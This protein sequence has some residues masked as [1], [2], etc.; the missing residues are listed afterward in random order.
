MSRF[1]NPQAVL[2]AL[3]NVALSSK[4]DTGKVMEA[5]SKD[6]FLCRVFSEK[7]PAF[8]LKGGQSMLARTTFARE[9]RDIDFMYRESD[10]EEAIAQLRRIAEMDLDDFFRFEYRGYD[11]IK[12]ED[13]YRHG[14]SIHFDAY[15][16]AKKQ[17]AVNIDLVSDP[18][19]TGTPTWLT[20]IAR[21]VVGDLPIFD[22]L[23]NPL[24]N[25]IADK[26]CAIMEKHADDKPSSRVK[27]LVDLV[28]IA[29]TQTVGGDA[30]SIQLANE[31]RTRH[32]EDLKTLTPP[33]DWFS[34][35]AKSYERSARQSCLD[36]ELM[37]ITPGFVLASH[38]VN[39]LFNDS[40]NGKSWNPE[41]RS[42]E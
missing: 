11:P 27:D 9:T 39:P 6:R 5:F 12:P 35:R 34:V 28:V 19:F 29:C 1:S 23:V 22:Y 3:K 7:E 31:L 20:P 26:V 41:A 13:E 40:A 17:T 2:S 36:N 37:S 10:L 33:E 24:E 16:G 42:W 32:L 38:L 14:Y 15:C 18:V 21:P 25:T 4:R 8:V 30:A